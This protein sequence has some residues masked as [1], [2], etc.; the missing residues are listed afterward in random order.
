MNRLD[1]LKRLGLSAAGLAIVSPAEIL[2][3][4]PGA[5]ATKKNENPLPEE[6]KPSQDPIFKP[7]PQGSPGFSHLGGIYLEGVLVFDFFSWRLDINRP[8]I[9]VTTWDDAMKGREEFITGRM[10]ATLQGSGRMIKTLN[11]WIDKKMNFDIINPDQDARFVGECYLKNIAS[12]IPERSLDY[13]DLDL[14]VTGEIVRVF[15]RG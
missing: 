10:E 5:N 8:L 1:F 15:E 4:I 3:P 13:F 14:Q 7:A 12:R 9:D 6:V 11:S 2:A